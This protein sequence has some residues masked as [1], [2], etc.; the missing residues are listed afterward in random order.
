M[1]ARL[2][3]EP[4]LGV[5]GRDTLFTDEFVPSTNPHGNS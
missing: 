2:C 4:T 3:T 1:A 5:A